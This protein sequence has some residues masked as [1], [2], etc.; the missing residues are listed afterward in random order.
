M[1]FRDK[2]IKKI[3]D[4]EVNRICRKVI[5]MLTKIKDILS[6]DDSG[7]EN[8]WDEICVQVQSQQSIYWEMYEAMIFNS[9]EM[10]VND[11]P[12][13]LQQAIWL[14]TR[15]GFDWLCDIDDQDEATDCE[16]SVYIDNILNYIL[17]EILG[18]ADEWSNPRIRMYIDCQIGTG[19]S[20]DQY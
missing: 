4:D 18:K 13:H 2:L 5:S 20:L 14:Q 17:G 8:A 10:V 7:L 11:I 1:D 12:Y 19:Q 3:A 6:G 15:A 16:P 9:I